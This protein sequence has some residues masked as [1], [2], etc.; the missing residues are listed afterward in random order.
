MRVIPDVTFGIA[1]HLMCWWLP[2]GKGRVAA[3]RKEAVR[4][5]IIGRRKARNTSPPF[6]RGPS[7]WRKQ[8]CCG[9]QATTYH[10]AFAELASYG[11]EVL[12][13]KVVR[14]GNII[15]AAVSAPALNS[16]YIC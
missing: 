10:T 12:A 11:V 9:Q 5:F 4:E 3:M 1:P 15:T 8:A 13:R 14:E 6:A 7:C 2:G 16:A